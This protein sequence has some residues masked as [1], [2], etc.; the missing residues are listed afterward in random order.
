MCVR[1]TTA[2][3]HSGRTF[4]SVDII[5]VKDRGQDA[6]GSTTCLSTWVAAIAASNPACHGSGSTLH[7]AARGALEYVQVKHGFV[8]MW[9]EH[10][11]MPAFHVSIQFVLV[12]EAQSLHKLF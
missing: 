8:K 10:V 11:S 5:G 9:I 12:A 3:L 2:Y 7:I 1:G 6:K 4:V